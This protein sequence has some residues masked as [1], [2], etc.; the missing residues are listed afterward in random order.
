KNSNFAIRDNAIVVRDGHSLDYEASASKTLFVKA[1]DKAGASVIEAV[2]LNVKDANDAPF[3][4][5]LSETTISEDAAAGT[6][7][8][9]LST[10]DADKGDSHSYTLVDA[11]GNEVKNSNFAIRDNAIVVRDGHSLDYEASA[12]KTLFVK[13]TDKA[14]ASVM[15]A[16]TLNVKDANDAPVA[17][18]ETITTSED[19]PISVQFRSFDE[20]AEVR[21]VEYRIE[22]LPSHGQLLLN[23]SP[24]EV[25]GI[26]SSVDQSEGRLR[27]FPDRNWH[28]EESITFRASDGQQWSDASAEIRINVAPLADAGSLV[29]EP[30]TGVAGATISLKIAAGLPDID[31]GED[32]MIYISGV[33]EGVTLNAGERQPDGT[34]MLLPADLNSLTMTLSPLPPAQFSLTVTVVTAETNGSTATTTAELEV[35]ILPGNERSDDPESEPEAAIPFSAVPD[36]R[37]EPAT[38]PTALPYAELPPARFVSHDASPPASDHFGVTP[39][40]YTFLL[41]ITETPDWSNTIFGEVRPM[42]FSDDLESSADPA[43]VHHTLAPAETT[44][45]QQAGRNESAATTNPLLWFWSAARALGGVRDE[46]KGR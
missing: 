19:Q 14:G 44:A 18:F 5:S 43:V 41:P 28:G 24:V 13:A 29:V 7:V 26:V 15:Q 3:A 39:L 9:K 23:G 38:A 30:A 10:S 12:S 6:V 22:S 27:F 37:R 42:T 40:G 8:G 25:G 2:T 31:S 33:P 4:V 46:R 45:E 11:K 1:T 16:V 21:T 34:W 17:V 35:N 36:P 32:L 20:D